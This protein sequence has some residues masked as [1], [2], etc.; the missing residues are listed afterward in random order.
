VEE[1]DLWRA[2]AQLL[3]MYP[4]GAELAAVNRA[5]KALAEGD[6]DGFYLWK[7]IAMIISN[8]YCPKRSVGEQVH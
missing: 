2:A 5:N 8:L 4:E 6:M 1:I 3:K 7:R